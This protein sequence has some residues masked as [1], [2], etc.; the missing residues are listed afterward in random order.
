MSRP[1][2]CLRAPLDGD[3]LSGLLPDL[4]LEIPPARRGLPPFRLERRRSAQ[5]TV[6]EG[7]VSSASFPF[8]ALGV[9]DARDRTVR[10]LDVEPTV[11]GHDPLCVGVDAVDGQVQVEVVGVAV[12]CVDTLVLAE[13]HL[14][15]E[16]PYGRVSLRGRGL[17]ALPPADDPVLDRLRRPARG[18][19]EVGHLVDH[20]GVIDVQHIRR[21]LVLDLLVGVARVR[22]GDV[23]AEVADVERL[24]LERPTFLGLD[25]LDDHARTSSLSYCPRASAATAALIATRAAAVASL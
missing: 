12:E 16:H 10:D 23:V 9:L 1:A 25:L 5:F 3:A 20:A 4:I 14:V 6:V 17:L 18:L 22:A 13:A 15:E 21:A 7:K 24:R 2:Q 19:G 11:H 8:P